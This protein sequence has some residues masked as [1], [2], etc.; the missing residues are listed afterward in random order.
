MMMHQISA[1]LMVGHAPQ[2]P[3]APSRESFPKDAHR[4][5]KYWWDR[6]QP[7]FVE[8]ILVAPDLL[9][10]LAWNGL[11]VCGQ[12]VIQSPLAAVRSALRVAQC[13]QLL[14]VDPTQPAL[15]PEIVAGVAAGAQSRWDVIALGGDIAAELVPV[16]FH[17]RCLKMMD[18]HLALTDYALKD[19]YHQVR[20]H[21]MD[22]QAVTS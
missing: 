18:H 19:F 20:L 3:A 21:T 10:E 12:Y 1:A 2:G 11:I 5:A 15:T 17:R 7:F 9:T 16:V 22:I 6:L 4:D 14:V 8:L 13:E